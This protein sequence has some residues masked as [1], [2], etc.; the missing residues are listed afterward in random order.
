[1]AHFIFASMSDCGNACESRSSTMRP[2]FMGTSAS[3]VACRHQMTAGGSS[4]WVSRTQSVT[5]Q[6]SSGRPLCKPKLNAVSPVPRLMVAGSMRRL[7]E[8]PKTSTRGTLGISS[9]TSALK[10]RS[11]PRL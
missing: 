8:P 4:G 9:Y 7:R 6:A 5:A 2:G 10:L 3:V 11:K 1:M